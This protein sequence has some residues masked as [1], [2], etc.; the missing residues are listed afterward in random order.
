MRE[1]PLSHQ[2]ANNYAASQ[3]TCRAGC[4]RAL[5]PPLD[6]RPS[7]TCDSI[8]ACGS[9]RAGDTARGS[10]L[11]TRGSALR[12]DLAA[13]SSPKQETSGVCPRPEPLHRSSRTRLRPRRAPSPAK[14]CLLVRPLFGRLERGCQ[15]L[16]R[17]CCREDVYK[18]AKYN[19]WPCQVRCSVLTGQKDDKAFAHSPSRAALRYDKV[20][21]D[22]LTAV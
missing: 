13:S 14:T 3:E 12:A 11:C 22:F 20:N 4:N 5:E 17:T 6:T 19:R 9:D 1:A 16:G 15:V 21:S 8:M 18:S 7:P 2:C 10:Q